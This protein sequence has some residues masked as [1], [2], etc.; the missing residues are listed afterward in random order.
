[1]NTLLAGRFKAAAQTVVDLCGTPP[2]GRT[3][4][5]GSIVIAQDERPVHA[6]ILTK[7]LVKL[8]S[9]DRD[10][11]ESGVRVRT[12]GSILGTLAAL[13]EE[14]QPCS[15]EAITRCEAHAIPSQVLRERAAHDPRVCS[16]LLVLHT[17]E[18]FAGVAKGAA[19]QSARSRVEQILGALAHEAG[20]VD[21]PGW[22]RLALPVSCEY[23]ATLAGITPETFSRSLAQLEHE[24]L[25]ER[26]R[27]WLRLRHPPE[28]Y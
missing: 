4:A 12:A 21:Q 2:T 27:G 9:Y 22:V 11:R 19:S 16:A 10:G 7:G 5:G 18:A 28:V 24:G 15:I 1:M 26:G 25:L 13:L 17:V 3:F 8:S 6:F 23:L 20:S 14:R